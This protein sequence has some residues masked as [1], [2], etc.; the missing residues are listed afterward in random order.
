MSNIEHT[1]PPPHRTLVVDDNPAMLVALA[2][3]LRGQTTTDGRTFA[4]AVASGMVDAL[5][6]LRAS[7]FDCIVVDWVMP[8]SDPTSDL[9][10]MRQLAP[11]AAIVL[12]SGYGL[13]DGNTFQ[14]CRDLFEHFEVDAFILKSDLVRELVPALEAA[15]QRRKTQG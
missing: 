5:T 8:D 15:M 10:K 14:T 4:L 9:L 3:F 12:V 7:V 11:R 13:S 6:A 2:T 1:R